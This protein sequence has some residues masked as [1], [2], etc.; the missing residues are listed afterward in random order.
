MFKKF[1]IKFLFLFIL[2]LFA[3]NCNAQDRPKSKFSAGINLG[4]RTA[5]GI[6][7]ILSYHAN[8]VVQVDL[9]AGYTRWNGAKFGGGGK[10]YPFK[11][12]KV[13]PFVSVC[14]SISM[15]ANVGT[16]FKF[17]LKEHYRTFSNQYIIPGMGITMHGE[18]TSHTL[19]IGYS[20][21]LTEPIV[22]ILAP[23]PTPNNFERVHNSL[24]GG[25]MVTYNL[26]IFFHKPRKR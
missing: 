26:F 10:I 22:N 17:T 21:M 11:F 19:Q 20:F 7:I 6:G 14:Y 16:S 5:N 8:R 13:N 1:I 9:L 18:E 15:G 25:I 4:Y 24:K 3:F 12:G 2:I 23:L